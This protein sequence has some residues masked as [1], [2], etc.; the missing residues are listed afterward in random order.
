MQT[1]IYYVC[2]ASV[3]YGS[4]YIPRCM[5]YAVMNIRRAFRIRRSYG[6]HP[7]HL[8]KELDC[9]FFFALTPVIYT[10]WMRCRKNLYLVDSNRVATATVLVLDDAESHLSLTCSIPNDNGDDIVIQNI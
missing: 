5:P 3:P 9:N 8:R 1:S 10:S 4:R 6:I 2:H 7:Y